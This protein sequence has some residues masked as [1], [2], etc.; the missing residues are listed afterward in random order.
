MASE[1]SVPK[2]RRFEAYWRQ[3]DAGPDTDLEHAAAD[4]VGGENGSTPAFAEHPAKDEVIDRGPA[5]VGLLDRRA[6]EVQ[7]PGT[8][9]FD[10]FCHD[11]SHSL[12]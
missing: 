1:I 10:D 6:V 7:L 3:R 11:D 8:V 4:A 9:K 5:V 2:T 12:F